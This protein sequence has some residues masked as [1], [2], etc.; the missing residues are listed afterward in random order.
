MVCRVAVIFDGSADIA[1]FSVSG[2]DLENTTPHCPFRQLKWLLV[3]QK[4]IFFYILCFQ[5]LIQ[6][7]CF[8]INRQSSMVEP[9]LKKNKLFT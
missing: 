4:Y 6:V 9:V 8:V 2:V 5:L 7:G 1:F 3:V